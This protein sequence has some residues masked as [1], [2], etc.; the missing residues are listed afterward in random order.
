M[1]LQLSL[2]KQYDTKQTRGRLDIKYP[3]LGFR[4]SL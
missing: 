2:I 1:H 3:Y 4:S